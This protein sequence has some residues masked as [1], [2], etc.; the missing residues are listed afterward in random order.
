[1]P[2]RPEAEAE[3][4]MPVEGF[5]GRYWRRFSSKRRNERTDLSL[6]VT[7]STFLPAAFA[8]CLISFQHERH[9]I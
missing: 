5:Q 3:K 1:M 7:E 6:F 8:A 9:W 4:E 2:C